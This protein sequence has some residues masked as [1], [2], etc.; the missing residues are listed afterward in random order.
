MQLVLGVQGSQH[1]PK[2]YFS[3]KEGYQLLLQMTEVLLGSYESRWTTVKRR[4]V[5]TLKVRSMEA[6][7]LK[8]NTFFVYTVVKKPPRGIVPY[9]VPLYE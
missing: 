4:T 8:F 3:D 2:S 7:N 1:P 6:L 9:F 5:P